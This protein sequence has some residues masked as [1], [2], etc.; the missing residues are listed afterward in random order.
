MFYLGFAIVSGNFPQNTSFM[1][2]IVSF[3]LKQE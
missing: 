3:L 2:F 1:Y